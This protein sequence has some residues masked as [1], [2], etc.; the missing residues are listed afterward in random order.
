MLT[1]KIHAQAV[2]SMQQHLVQLQLPVMAMVTVLPMVSTLACYLHGLVL[3]VRHV[4][5]T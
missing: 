4:K 2:V 5:M 3:L 1:T